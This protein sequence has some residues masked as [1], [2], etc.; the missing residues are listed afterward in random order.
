MDGRDGLTP[1]EY[2]IGVRADGIECRLNG[3]SKPLKKL[4]QE[5]GIPAWLRDSFPIIYSVQSDG[6]RQV[7]A[8]GDQYIC[9]GYRCGQSGAVTWNY[10]FD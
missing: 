10:N 2:Q 9:D 4:L 6:S 5:A 3:Q 7:A 8:I 1:G